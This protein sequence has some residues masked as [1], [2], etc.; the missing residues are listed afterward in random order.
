MSF[1]SPFML[2]GL[3]LDPGRA[4]RLLAR[5]AAA[6]QVRG[7]LHEPRPARERRRRLARPAAAHS[8]CARARRAR[9]ARRRDGEA[10]GG[11]RRAAG[12]RHGRPDDGQLGVDD[13]DRRRAHAARRREVGRVVVP[14]QPVRTGSASASSRSRAPSR[15]SR[16]RRTTATPSGTSLESIQGD[17]GTALGDAHRHLGRPGSGSQSEQEKLSGGKPLFA[18]LLLSD[19]ANSTGSEP[20]NVLDDAKKTGVPVY[21][22]ALGTDSGTVEITND[23]GADRDLRR[24]ARSRDAQEGRARRPAGATSRRRPRPTSR[25]STSRSDPRSRARTRSAS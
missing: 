21:T 23:L 17:V 6:N 3:L 2:W 10:A 15:S 22:I 14:R 19:G 4:R 8:G 1:A 24:P 13:R 18:V 16:S 7:A 11:R 9:R 12:R 20:L 25:R 5:A